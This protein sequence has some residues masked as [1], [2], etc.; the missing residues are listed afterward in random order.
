[1]DI[2]FLQENVLSL[3]EMEG[4][5]MGWGFMIAVDFNGKTGLAIMWRDHIPVK[6]I[7]NIVDGR[8][9]VASLGELYFIT[10]IC[11]SLV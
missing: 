7:T 10:F 6:E 8:V 2:V 3:S 5:V 11:S 9:M 4:L 1:M